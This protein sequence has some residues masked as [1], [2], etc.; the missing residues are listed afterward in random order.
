MCRGKSMAEA[1][2]ITPP[3]LEKVGFNALEEPKRPQKESKASAPPFNR[4]RFQSGYELA[5]EINAFIYEIALQQNIKINQEE[6]QEIAANITKTIKLL[7]DE[8]ITIQ[9]GVLVL[10]SS[11]T[12][13]N[14]QFNYKNLNFGI[15]A[16]SKNAANEAKAYIESKETS[17]EFKK[18][19]QKM[20]KKF[21]KDPFGLEQ[22]IVMMAAYYASI[23]EKYR[24]ET[25]L[26]KNEITSNNGRNDEEALRAYFNGSDMVSGQKVE[27]LVEKLLLE[28]YLYDPK[29]LKEEKEKQ[30]PPIPIKEKEQVEGR[31][32]Y[33]DVSG[34][35]IKLFDLPSEEAAELTYKAVANAYKRWTNKEFKP[36]VSK[37]GTNYSLEIT[38]EVIKNSILHDID[39]FTFM[40]LEMQESKLRKYAVS[41]ANCKG[42]GQL[43]EGTFWDRKK[44]TIKAHMA[45]YDNSRDDAIEAL[46][47]DIPLNVSATAEHIKWLDK[48]YFPN[49]TANIIRAYNAGHGPVLAYKRGRRKT[50][51]DETVNY[52]ANI[53][54]LRNL[55]KQELEKLMGKELKP[56]KTLGAY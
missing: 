43:A 27:Y 36:N 31:K 6:I 39:P 23:E 40:A 45:Q 42:P 48:N 10:I 55:I 29:D 53:I 26:N 38:R 56:G 20:Y 50:L 1:L 52:L 49:D 5:E 25:N 51:P 22:N 19:F 28:K 44:A 34:E 12:N 54:K 21:Q 4:D 14:P 24:G 16:V 2:T 33:A 3:M 32:K 8:K 35:K 13:F 15:G 11:I 37:D 17:Q 7:E 18:F 30:K 41:C 47:Y 9:S 46:I